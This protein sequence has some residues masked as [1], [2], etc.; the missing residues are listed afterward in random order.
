MYATW[1]SCMQK[2]RAG[3]WHKAHFP[4]V[5]LQA[6]NRLAVYPDHPRHLYGYG[7]SRTK[8][9]Q[10]QAS[11]VCVQCLTLTLTLTLILTL[12]LA[13]WEHLRVPCLGCQ[14]IQQRCFPTPTAT[15][16]TPDH[17]AT[18]THSHTHSHLGPMIAAT[19]WLWKPPET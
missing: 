16:H 8:H 18:H 3:L 14:R 1:G 13:W 11:H 4:P 17:L 7:L 6:G 5:V 2:G 15:N 19:R 12:T 9:G 10:Q